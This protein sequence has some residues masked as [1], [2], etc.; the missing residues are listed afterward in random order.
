MLFILHLVILILNPTACL[1]SN[2][3]EQ[4]PK[5]PNPRPES[6]AQHGLSLLQMDALG[7]PGSGSASPKG[8]SQAAWQGAHKTQ[9]EK[10]CSEKHAKTEGL[11][12]TAAWGKSQN[13][14]FP[15]GPGAAMTEWVLLH[16]EQICPTEAAALPFL[17][18]PMS[19]APSIKAVFYTMP[20]PGE[21]C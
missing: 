19:A 5:M 17:F 18:P 1:L 14:K 12:L 16:Q 7:V 11:G 2:P 10:R 4:V 13:Q 3:P 15:G 9:L 8:S 6:A 21:V 20:L